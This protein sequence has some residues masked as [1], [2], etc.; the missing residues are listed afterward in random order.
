[1]RVAIIGGGSV[2]FVLAVSACI[3][4]GRVVAVSSPQAVAWQGDP[5]GVYEAEVKAI[6][7]AGLA[8]ATQDRAAGVVQTQWHQTYHGGYSAMAPPTRRM[9][10]TLAMQ[11]GQVVVTPA[12]ELCNDRGCRPSDKLTAPEVD[13]S[14][15]VAGALRTELQARNEL[16]RTDTQVVLQAAREPA[17]TPLPPQ[18]PPQVVY[19]PVPAA[20]SAPMP[21]G[22]SR[23]DQ[24]GPV[25]IRTRAAGMQEVVAGRS[26]DVELANG[27]RISGTL[28]GVS[29]DGIVVDAGTGEGVVI[30]VQD[31]AQVVVRPEER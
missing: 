10:F 4:T 20:T 22:P 31:I 21:R 13:L 15:R 17:P 12:L 2:A 7:D 11:R 30:W 14:D 5:A 16:L 1:M 27:N 29:P 24:H 6:A 26:V 18:A 8:I 9:M 3:P 19:V 28:T 23:P 25:V